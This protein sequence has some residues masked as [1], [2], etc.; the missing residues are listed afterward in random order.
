MNLKVYGRGEFVLKEKL[1]LLKEKLK[2]WNKEVFGRKEATTRIWRNLRIKE[3]MLL[4]KARLRWVKEG[5]ANNGFFHKVMKEKRSFN[6]LGPIATARGMAV[7]VEEVR[8]A[9]FNHFRDKFVESEEN[10]PLLEGGE[11]KS[12][13]G[14]MAA[15]LE[16]PFLEDEIKEA[17][18]S[19]GGDKCSG[20]N[21]YSFLFI[22]KCWDFIKDDFVSFFKYFYSGNV[23]SKAISSSFLSLIPKTSNPLSLDDYR[24]ICLEGKE[25]FLL[26]KVDF[27]KACD[28]VSWSFFRYMLKRM[29]F[30]RRWM[31]WMEMLVFNSS[32][33]VLVN[34]S[35]TKE[36]G[37]FKGLRQG[38]PLSSFLYV[39]VAEGLSGLVR[40]SKEIGEFG[41]FCI[42]SSCWVDILQF[43]DDTLLVGEGTW[44]HVKAIKGVLRAFEIAS[45][46]GINYHKSKL[47]GINTRSSFLEAATL[48]L[49]CK[50]EESNFYVL[51][52]PIGFDPRKELTW[53]P[54]VVKLKKH[55]GSWKNRFLNLGGRITL[56]KSILTS[57]TIFTM[58]FYKMPLKIVKEVNKIQNNFL[59]GGMEEKRKIHWVS[60]KNVILSFDKGGIRVKNI[61]VFNQALLTKW[62]WRILQGHDSLWLRVLKSR[63][64]MKIGRSFF[65]DPIVE[66]CRFDVHNGY[67]T[68]FWEANWWGGNILKD[69]FPELYEAFSLKGV[70]VAI[71]GGW[72]EG[73]WRWGDFGVSMTMEAERGL[74]E[75]ILRLKVVLSEFGEVGEG[76][77]VV[78]WNFNSDG[79]FSVASCY[80]FLGIAFIPQGPPNKYNEAYGLV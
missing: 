20:P 35:P 30:G 47:I 51:G 32:M 6:H 79:V 80:D 57:L 53:K 38:D 70:S 66:G 44:K 17:V 41:S 25:K 52:I 64:I 21:G 18:W 78:S 69:V 67:N 8:E 58:S 42:K 12:I 56:L 72:L 15:N 4:Q 49:S 45:G 60:W 9:V 33:S 31:G 46:L 65:R 29:S 37:V 24:P 36:F 14:E 19:C 27:E 3:N 5:D 40:K 13:S 54:L 74:S 16:K 1:R 23:I 48:F 73:R 10:R 77:D 22:K 26:F 50:V 28:K 63:D 68:P 61:V 34:G 62:R 59:R 76:R 75:R 43:T 2:V 11:F 39:L 55:L 7:S 71:M